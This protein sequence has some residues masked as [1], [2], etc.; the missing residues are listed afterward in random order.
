MTKE[1]NYIPYGKEW[2]QEL[3]KWNKT[4]L[5]D[6]IRKLLI[7]SQLQQNKVEE[8]E[9]KKIDDSMNSKLDNAC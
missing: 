1:E 4:M 6:F 9:F 5:I 8:M 3:K 7:E 2:E